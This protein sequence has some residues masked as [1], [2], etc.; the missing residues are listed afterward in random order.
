MTAQTVAGA[1]G[2][3]TNDGA[4][5][6]A[7][8]NR[9]QGI[10]FTLDGSSVLIAD[11][12]NQRIRRL[13]IQTSMV[14][15]FANHGVPDCSLVAVASGSR[16]V[17][18]SRSQ[19]FALSL[20][21]GM[22]QL[23][24]PRQGNMTDAHFE[25]IR[26]V[27]ITSDGMHVLVAD[28]GRKQLLRVNLTT[29][30]MDVVAGNGI[31]A[32]DGFGTNAAFSV[33]WA[34]AVNEEHAFIADQ[35]KIRTIELSTSEVASLAGSSTPGF[36]DGVGETAAFDTIL[37]LAA[38]STHVY[39]AD[40][41]NNRIRQ[42]GIA[43]GQVEVLAGSGVD[44]SAEGELGSASFS[45]PWG[46]AVG[47]RGAERRIAVTERGSHRVRWVSAA[48][49]TLAG[50]SSSGFAD[51][52][53]MTARFDVPRG[54]APL[55]NGRAAVADSHNHR[56]RSLD[57][58]SGVVS[59]LAGTG[60]EGFLDGSGSEARFRRPRGITTTPD[61]ARLVVADVGNERIRVVDIASGQVRTLG[62]RIAALWG[63]A[64]ALGG[65]MVVVSGGNQIS[66]IPIEGGDGDLEVVAGA[67]A[68]GFSDGQGSAVR[69][70]G[71]R[72]LAV[73]PDGRRVVIADAGNRMV[74]A[75]ELSSGAVSTIAGPGSG[76][77]T[78]GGLIGS[79]E[80]GVLDLD[81]PAE[82]ALTPDG[83]Y[84]VVLDGASARV[85]LVSMA[86]GQARTLW[87]GAQT[88]ALFG[89]ALVTQDGQRAVLSDA[90]HSLLL[91]LSAPLQCL[92]CENPVPVRA[93]YTGVGADALSCPWQC[94]PG[95]VA[96]R[97]ASQLCSGSACTGPEASQPDCAACDTCE[98]D[99]GY[100]GAGCEQC[101]A[102]AH[103]ASV[104]SALCSDCEVG[105]HQPTPGASACEQCEP[106]RFQPQAGAS[107]C[108]ECPAGTFINTSGASACLACPAEHSAS[109]AGSTSVADCECAPGF[110]G[111]GGELVCVE[112]GPGTF[113]PD[114]G[115]GACERCT[116]RPLGAQY[117][118]RE[119]GP[120]TEDACLWECAAGY[121]LDPAVGSM[122]QCA[123]ASRVSFTTA[124]YGITLAVFE[125]E[126]R[127]AWLS[128][129]AVAA[130]VQRRDVEIATL[131]E[132]TQQ[133]LRGLA[134]PP[135]PA[136]VDAESD[137]SKAHARVASAARREELPTDGVLV[138][139]LVWVLHG[140]E[141][142]VRWL[143][144]TE[145][146]QAQVPALEVGP[147]IVD[148]IWLETPAPAELPQHR[149]PTQASIFIVV[150]TIA[151]GFLLF[152]CGILAGLY[153]RKTQLVSRQTR[154]AA[155]SRSATGE[156]QTAASSSATGDLVHPP[157]LPEVLRQYNI[158]AAALPH[159]TPARPDRLS[160]GVLPGPAAPP[161]SSTTGSAQALG[162]GPNVNPGLQ[163]EIPSDLAAPAAR[164]ISAAHDPYSPASG[165]PGSEAS[166]SAP[167][168]GFRLVAGPT[169][170]GLV[171]QP[172]WT[173]AAPSPGREGALVAQ[174]VLNSSALHPHRP[175]LATTSSLGAP[176]SAPPQPASAL[177]R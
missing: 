79:V 3:W 85:V 148:Y 142:V 125:A 107:R 17:V 95:T 48:V 81:E 152:L 143:L 153:Y 71:A 14:S 26:G 66:K 135:A 53:N 132:H 27:A 20:A 156:P 10:S 104:G 49:S 83:A 154:A 87:A 65:S 101:P 168:S 114:A 172:V 166:E 111:G 56:I 127:E 164:R 43:T 46:V 82:V 35:H 21:T 167:R 93:A 160:T 32:A 12:R 110:T 6:L 100:G 149:D 31:G 23:I 138:E 141:S 169:L 161:D 151:G 13:D 129:V 94:L 113:K 163:L 102:G 55:P 98:C 16:A 68:A 36:A 133:Q 34:V 72:G 176:S 2:I 74:R 140:S 117:K 121:V 38:T 60:V 40:A 58:A 108:E 45:H 92:P 134:H 128:G 5:S 42:V 96:R 64:V 37:A 130:Q 162:P 118:T 63:V 52:V 18:A 69:F 115:P 67:A 145:N 50:S 62:P 24:N 84:V 136:S 39:V 70:D 120:E 44:G 137:S 30:I 76:L 57:L 78:S 99:V 28:D 146:L 171:Q 124:L 47:F 88:S 105:A 29:G 158:D 123:E 97:S 131:Q 144:T 22:M 15:T 4:F 89:A 11:V 91:V 155:P 51:G 116:R 19:L 157:P 106:G 73:T 80:A 8:F 122:G 112:C 7:K 59:T 9:P 150:G 165:A 177:D 90:T 174:E 159:P 61:R 77:Q 25:E 33:L 126:Y 54:L 41:G 139:T 75:L 1:G 86:S 109:P 147:V 119:A 170:E 103:K 175:S 173:R